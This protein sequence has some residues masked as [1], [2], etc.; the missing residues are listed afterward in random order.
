M[1][2][3]DSNPG[4]IQVSRGERRHYCAIFHSMFCLAYYIIYSDNL[5]YLFEIF[6]IRHLSLLSCYSATG[7]MKSNDIFGIT[8]GENE[9][10][11]I[12]RS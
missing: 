4:N 5:F 8:V 3:R 10:A 12:C 1:K 7:K 2:Q 9:S 6:C 11:L